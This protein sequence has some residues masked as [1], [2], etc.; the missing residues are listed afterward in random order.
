MAEHLLRANGVEQ[1]LSTDDDFH[2]LELND[3]F[4]AS[5]TQSGYRH[6]L[7]ALVDPSKVKVLELVFK[8]IQESLE[9]DSYE[10][11][12]SKYEM[13]LISF[14]EFVRRLLLQKPKVACGGEK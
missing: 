10:N 1:I 5:S 8:R 7:V 3:S 6:M 2:G 14:E 9:K 11:K 13:M 4:D 12:H